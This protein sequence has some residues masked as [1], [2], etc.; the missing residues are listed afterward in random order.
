MTD[1]PSARSGR[2]QIDQYRDGANLQ[3]RMVLY[4][5]FGTNDRSWHLWIFD[6]LHLPES[7]R[8]LELGCG[9]GALWSRN[10][11]RLPG[12]WRI[13]LSDLS[14]GILRDAGRALG[15]SKPRFTWLVADADALPLPDRTFDCVIAN[16]MLYHVPSLD[17]TLS[18][19]RR[20]LK[21]D[22]RLFATT[23][24][25]DHMQELWQL[26]TA[27]DPEMNSPGNNPN[28]HLRFSLENGAASLSPYFARISLHQYDNVLVVSEAEAFVGY[29]L[30]TSRAR[31]LTKDPRRL[32]EFRAFVE[33]H[34]L[35]HGPIRISTSSGLFEAGRE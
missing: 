24:G 16:H 35:R 30:S 12:G 22:G 13:V 31:C 15:A 28:M 14:V 29:V 25:R 4:D 26:V 27:F 19:I 3:A 32:T 5:R 9:T 1:M 33:D 8:V 10:L 2:I 23:N 34:L 21:S 6:H 7:S 18:E 17:A 11:H 20:V